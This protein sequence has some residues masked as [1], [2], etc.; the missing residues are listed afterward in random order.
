MGH[1]RALRPAQP[2]NTRRS[3]RAAPSR[4]S[5]RLRGVR[6][7]PHLRAFGTR[8]ASRRA[9]EFAWHVTTSVGYTPRVMTSV[10]ISRGTSRRTLDTRH[11]S[12][13]AFEYARH[14]TTSVGY[15][16]FVTAS[17]RYTPPT[18][19]KRTSTALLVIAGVECAGPV[20]RCVAQVM[21]ERVP[22]IKSLDRAAGRAPQVARRRFKGV[23]RR[24]GSKVRLEGAARR[25]GSCRSR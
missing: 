14:V 6:H 10:R 1:L 15:A 12:R 19:S 17:G 2:P 7:E 24:C 21:S 3:T 25:C 18:T 23:A 22:K 11:A 8:H 9:F 20:P 16:P 5:T 13:R 4:P